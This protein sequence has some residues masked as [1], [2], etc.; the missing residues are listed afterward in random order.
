M[1]LEL[2]KRNHWVQYKV[3]KRFGASCSNIFS[4]DIQILPDKN[5]SGSVG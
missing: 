2:E 4:D 3:A 1:I 5:W